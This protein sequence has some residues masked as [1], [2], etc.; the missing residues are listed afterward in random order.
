MCS[1]KC[2]SLC[3]YYGSSLRVEPNA[4]SL[5]KQ[6]DQLGPIHDLTNDLG[7]MHQHITESYGH[8]PS[9]HCR[10]GS[11]WQLSIRFD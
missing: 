10:H 2:G 5:A 4:S 6:F 3:Y 8:V 1:I 11:P 7:L 9:Y